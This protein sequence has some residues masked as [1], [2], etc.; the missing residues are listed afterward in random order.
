M[1]YIKRALKVCKTKYGNSHEKTHKN[2]FKMAVLQKHKENQNQIQ[3][4]EIRM[5]TQKISFKS[6][7]T[8]I[9]RKSNKNYVNSYEKKHKNKF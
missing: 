6:Y 9:Q 8:E 1:E 7:I 5:K 4:T 3:I 2:W